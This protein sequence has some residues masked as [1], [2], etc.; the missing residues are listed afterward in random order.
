MKSDTVKE[1][2]EH[3]GVTKSHN[4]PHTSDDN[5]FSEAQFKTVKYHPEFPGRFE[6][7]EDA[8]TFCRR[9]FSWYNKVHYHSG[10]AWLTPESVHYGRA[11]EI[12]EKR[13]RV[14]IAA[15]EAHPT[16]FNNKK[17]KLKKLPEAVYINPPQT[18]VIGG[19]QEGVIAA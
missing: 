18:V 9:F 15:F 4:R 19:L 8:E 12:L 7:I 16:R 3:L 10:L 6:T 14:L 11:N 5:P 2:L 1:L 17:P 13:H